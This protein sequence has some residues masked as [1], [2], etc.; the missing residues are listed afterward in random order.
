MRLL[1]CLAL[2]LTAALLPAQ[3][4]DF[5]GI[6]A[7]YTVAFA[8]SGTRGLKITESPEA[9]AF[10]ERMK[11]RIAK[12]DK[13]AMKSN[14]ELQAAIKAA[15]GID[16]ESPDSWFAGGCLIDDN[17][18]LIARSSDNFSGGLI[19]HAHHDS[20]KLAAYAAG[21]KIPAVQAGTTSGW[22][23]R[24]LLSSFGPAFE[25]MFAAKKEP[26]P[27]AVQGEPIGIFDLD[28]N[29]IVVAQPK[30]AV[31]I[32]ALLKGQGTSYALPAGLSTP[33]AVT[34]RPYAILTFDASRMPPST[35][36]ELTQSGFQRAFLA[37]GE[38]NS[39]QVL[40]ISTTFTSKEKATPLA[41]QAQGMMAMLP[42]MIAG[43]PR[44]P[45][46]EE[47]KALQ[48]FLGEIL[49]G[50]QPI[51]ATDNQVALIAKWDTVKFIGLIEKIM[52]IVEA[53][54]KAA[55]AAQAK[56]VPQPVT[57]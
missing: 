25:Q 3:D 29:T 2:V 9:K 38:N 42:M 28:D 49:A 54:A 47:E 52:P 20:R 31:R 12:D 19:Y 45:K 50:I 34:G 39:N 6:P 43:D 4:F 44:K 5:K 23:A 8:T 14:L 35:S 40:K 46:T 55:K 37:I 15:T 16:M 7:D 32:I 33:L 30:E 56:P 10:K 21:K 57:K 1:P 13:G 41:Q 36:K 27:Q 22:Q 18:P 48:A 11:A 17:F 26:A 51:E 24:E 53:Q